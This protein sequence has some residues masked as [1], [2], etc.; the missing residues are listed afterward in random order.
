MLRNQ[1]GACFY[2]FLTKI[3][4]ILAVRSLKQAM[5]KGVIGMLQTSWERVSSSGNS[6]V[7]IR[8]VHGQHLCSLCS[9][10]NCFLI[11]LR[12]NIWCCFCCL[13]NCN[14]FEEKRNQ[15]DFKLA[16]K[17]LSLQFFNRYLNKLW[18]WK[19]IIL[20]ASLGSVISPKQ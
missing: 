4:C 11:L 14:I 16:V 2:Y 12:L 7:K 13:I 3:A 1:R 10:Q 8:I 15:R 17:M 9:L 5:G 19:E 6:A 20:C 18:N